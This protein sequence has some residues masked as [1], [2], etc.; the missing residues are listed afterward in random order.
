MEGAHM[1]QT[2]SLP[3]RDVHSV[4]FVELEQSLPS[5]I[6]AISPFVDQLIRFILNFRNADGSETDIGVAVREA[7]ANAVIH[8]NAEKSYKR[9]HVLCRCYMDGEVLTVRDE[10]QGFVS[11]TVPDPT[12]P[13]NRLFTHGRRDLRHENSNGRDLLREWRRYRAHAKEIQ[14]LFLGGE[15]AQ[16]TWRIPIVVVA[17][18][19]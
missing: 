7:L 13:E 4:P 8:G 9:V 15:K 6:Q 14:R 11:S 16:M 19:L 10:G 5:Q 17:K 12:T 18:G 1:A 3:P 2:Q